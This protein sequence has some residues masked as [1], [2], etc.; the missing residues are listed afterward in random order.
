[1]VAEPVFDS[2]RTKQQLGY[3][4][5]AGVRLT[6]N[7]LGFA[8]TVLSGQTLLTVSC[9]FLLMFKTLQFYNLRLVPHTIPSLVSSFY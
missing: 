4:V 9:C 8:F 3:S 7:V 1:M 6:N 2:L 5:S